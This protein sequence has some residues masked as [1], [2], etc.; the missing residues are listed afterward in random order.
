MECHKMFLVVYSCF[1]K[2]Q[3]MTSSETATKSI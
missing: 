3:L 1:A 2:V